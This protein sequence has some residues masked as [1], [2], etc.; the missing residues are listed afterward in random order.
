MR[1]RTLAQLIV[2]V[3]QRADLLNSQ[4]VT[5]IELTEYISQSYTELYDML[6]SVR[7]QDYYESTRSI[8]T[9]GG[10]SEYPLPDDFYQMIQ[11]ETDIAGMKVPMIPFMRVEHGK[12][13][14]LP[15]SGGRSIKMYY[16]PTCSRLLQASDTA[17][18]INGFE[19][20]VVLDCA[21]KALEKEES[22]IQAL[23]LRKAQLT[24][25]IMAMAPER[26]AGMPER[27]QSIRER[28]NTFATAPVP[29]Y[30]MRGNII[31]FVEGA[32]AGIGW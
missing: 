11:V 2:D 6:V 4:H 19:E 13:S 25:R 28:R 22:D 12:W 27:I 3:R 21:M 31:E 7:G 24:D 10:Q 15:L 17:E 30:R 32:L 9:V 16:V 14:F 29:Y 18:G 8:M 1:S 26:D 23:A 20:Y 5:D